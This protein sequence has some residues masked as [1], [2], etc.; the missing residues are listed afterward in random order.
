MVS[1]KSLY[2]LFNR[3]IN[4]I[5]EEGAFVIKLVKA[6]LITVITDHSKTSLKKKKNVCDGK[7]DS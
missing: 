5:L 3:S 4:D 7:L 2:E 1:Q 6:P